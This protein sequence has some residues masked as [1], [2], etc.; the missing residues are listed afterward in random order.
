[1]FRRRQY[2][3]QYSDSYSNTS[4]C[5]HLSLSYPCLEFLWKPA[6][7]GQPAQSSKCVVSMLGSCCQCNTRCPTDTYCK[8]GKKRIFPTVCVQWNITV[9][10]CLVQDSF[11]VHLPKERSKLLFTP[12]ICCLRYQQIQSSTRSTPHMTQVCRSYV[13]I[14]GGSPQLVN[15]L[16]LELIAGPTIFLS[17]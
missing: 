15:G 10:W 11:M 6:V 17:Y 13:Y 5:D 3:L 8:L 9:W 16:S 12:P 2:C 1:M 4:K 7:F 14:L